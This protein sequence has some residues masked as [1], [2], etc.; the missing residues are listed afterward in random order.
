MCVDFWN[1]DGR[2]CEGS[3][4]GKQGFIHYNALIFSECETVKGKYK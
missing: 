1:P 3:V 4:K 2:M